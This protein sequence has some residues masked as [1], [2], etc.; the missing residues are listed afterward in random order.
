MP[1]ACE[2][3]VDVNVRPEV[4]FALLDDL[5]RTKEWL[6]PCT[7]LEK[8]APGSNVVGDKLK[9]AFKQGGSSGVMDGEI[10]ARTP[11][12][13]LQCVYRDRQFEVLVDFR[14]ESAPGG[15]KLTHVITIT[16]KSLMGKIM[17]PCIRLGLRGQTRT[18]MENI[19]TIL[20]KQP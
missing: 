14:V 16:P 10:L 2:H 18:A 5:P 11:N 19:K 1:I 12:E 7:S 3:A 15:S 13:R 8:V 4:A 6:P 9:Y 20:E 17:S